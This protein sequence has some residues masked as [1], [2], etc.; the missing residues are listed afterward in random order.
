MI[1]SYLYGMGNPRLDIVIYP[2]LPSLGLRGIANLEGEL[3]A[4]SHDDTYCMIRLT[5]GAKGDVFQRL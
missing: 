3:Q 4:N 1:S 5:F 2:C